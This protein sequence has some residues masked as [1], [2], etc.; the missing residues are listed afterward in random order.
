MTDAQF[1]AH[2]G[3]AYER[4]AL[5]PEFVQEFRRREGMWPHEFIASTDAQ[6][7]IDDL[8]A[9]D[10]LRRQKEAV[11]FEVKMKLVAQWR[12]AQEGN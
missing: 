6:K 9:D 11:D 3:R 12:A 1:Y 8:P 2:L 5:S 4:Y 10:P 7:F